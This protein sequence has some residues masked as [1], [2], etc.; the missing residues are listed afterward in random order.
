MDEEGH[1]RDA[2]ET[3]DY[4]EWKTA[5]TEAMTSVAKDLPPLRA[6]L[7]IS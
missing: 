5:T 6:Y 3:M 1:L 2:N 7:Q 4:C